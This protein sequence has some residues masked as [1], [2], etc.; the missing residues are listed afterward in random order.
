MIQVGKLFRDRYE[1]LSKLGEGGMGAVYKVLDTELNTVCALKVL[2]PDLTGSKEK[3]DRFLREGQSMSRISHENVARIFRLGM[4]GAPYIVMEY[5]EGKSLRELLQEQEKLSQNLALDLVTQI[6]DG[7]FAAHEKNVLHRD[8]KPDNIIVVPQPAA[9]KFLVKIVDFGLARFKSVETTKSQHL[10]QTGAV[11]GSV[12]YMSPE[13]CIGAKLDERSDVYSLGCVLFE[14]LTGHPP[15]QAESAISMLHMHRHEDVPQ[16]P[17]TDDS[18]GGVSGVISKALA[19]KPEDRYQSM[20]EFRDDLRDCMNGVTPRGA[21][22]ASTRGRSARKIPIL[23]LFSLLM[24]VGT[25]FFL[26]VFIWDSERNARLVLTNIPTAKVLT[27]ALVEAEVSRA[28]RKFRLTPEHHKPDAARVVLKTFANLRVGC[29]EG[30]LFESWYRVSLMWAGKPATGTVVPM[31]RLDQ[32]KSGRVLRVKIDGL[33]DFLQ[34]DGTEVMA[35]DVQH[36]NA[37]PPAAAP[38]HANTGAATNTSPATQPAAPPAAGTGTKRNT[39]YKTPVMNGAVP[40]LTGTAWK[41]LYDEA[42]NVVP[43]IRFTKRGTYD[44]VRYGLGSGM[45]GNYRQSGSTVFL[46]NEAYS[47]KFDGGSNILLLTGGGTTL[48]LLYNGITS[49]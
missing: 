6:C 20:Q 16:L 15:F 22:K 26:K 41:M 40:N 12:H 28:E 2:N 38:A 30:R 42:K 47:M 29:W 48:K 25:A 4:D 39:D 18:D 13:Q 32:D 31:Q 5:L 11:L 19:K 45:Q 35:K 34:P 9:E 21:I 43:L 3:K 33:A 7:M 24:I 23:I 27:P 49:D 17:K 10:T 36:S 37:S 14:C 1:V 8:L 44:T 46:N